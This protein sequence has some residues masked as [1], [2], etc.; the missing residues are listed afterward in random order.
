[1]LALVNAVLIGV[2]AIDGTISFDYW[3]KTLHPSALARK[4]VRFCLSCPIGTIFSSGG[5]LRFGNVW[6][7]RTTAQ[8]ASI[9]AK[10]LPRQ[11]LG[12]AWNGI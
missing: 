11:T 8:E 6:S 3:S 7:M 10:S 9:N 4:M 2:H 12:P 1:M 5:S